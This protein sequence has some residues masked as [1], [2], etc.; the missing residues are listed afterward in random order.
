MNELR[1]IMNRADSSSLVLGD[2]LC[3]GTET[4]SA[5]KIVYAGLHMLCQIRSTFVFT[6]HLHQLTELDELNELKNLRICHLDIKQDNDVLIYDRKLKPGPGPSIYGMKVCEALG[7]SKEFLDIAR[8]ID[9]KKDN[10]KISP[11]NKKIVLDEC[12]ICGK[13]AEETHH[14][15]E[16]CEADSNGNLG[17]FHKNDE[18]NLVQLCKKCHLDVTHGNLI[19]EGYVQT[20]NG[21]ILKYN[22]SDK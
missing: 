6:S 11:Y 1:S 12:K 19:I 15:V 7:L 22:K 4:V 16:Q 17:H 13:K 10:L 21:I 14:I 8:S 3:S 9:I 20:G 18:H 2:E 5:I